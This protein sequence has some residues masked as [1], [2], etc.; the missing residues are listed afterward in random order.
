MGD[1][2]E[3]P[4]RSLAASSYNG[5]WALL[6]RPRT[7]DEDLELLELALTSRH[8]WR[9]AGGPQELAVADWMVSRCLAELGDGDLSLRFALAARQA[10]PSDAPAWLRAS[11]LEGLARAHAARGDRAARDAAVA[12]ATEALAL[13]GDDEDRALIADQ[14]ATV[15]ELG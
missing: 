5:C 11:L 6:E 8:H 3:V 15:P 4:H 2:G 12:R 14:L 1:A 7:P 10:A 9:A 13:E